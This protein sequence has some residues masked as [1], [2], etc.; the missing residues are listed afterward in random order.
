M[1]NLVVSIEK[2]GVGNMPE[3]IMAF[4]RALFEW[5]IAFLDALSPWGNL[6]SII[7]FVLSIWLMI[8]TGKIKQN[9]DKALEKN[10]K[11]I[12]Y[13]NM[14]SDILSGLEECARYLVNE[15]SS[16]ERLP[17]IHKLDGCLSDLVACYPNLTSSM[18][19][20]ID[21]IRSS[22]TRNGIN[23]SFIQII[24]PL[25]NVISILKMEAITL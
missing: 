11:I 7:G 5:L 4:L 21:A 6:C 22:C 10:N 12:N 24:K 3:N 14:R 2:N 15:H 13:I 25:N 20:D 8:Q 16:E 1:E 17:Y 19:Q 9:V 23:F 18:K